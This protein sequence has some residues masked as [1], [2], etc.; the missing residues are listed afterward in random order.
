MKVRDIMT[1]PAPMVT[2]DTRVGDVAR[3]MLA[4]GGDGVAVVDVRGALVGVV[5]ENDLV[6]KHARF[7]VPWYV[8]FLGGVIPI[9]SARNEEH[10]RHVLSV[11]AGDLMSDDP[12]TISPDAEVDDAATK[13]V[14][15]GVE[16]LI[17]VEVDAVVGLLS[18]SDVI[19]LLVVE[20]SDDGPTE[21]A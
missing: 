3:L 10:M 12:A 14:D 8:G 17:V 1:T 16:P 21:T 2:T 18:H 15:R 11:T 19:R 13:M 7:H 9:D 6:A 4:G 5:T 20:E